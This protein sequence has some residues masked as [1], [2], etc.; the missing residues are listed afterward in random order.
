M[1]WVGANTKFWRL[2]I[3]LSL[4]L[5]SPCQ[6]VNQEL[7]WLLPQQEIVQIFHNGDALGQNKGSKGARTLVNITSVEGRSTSRA[8]K[9]RGPTAKQKN[10]SHAGKSRHAR[11]PQWCLQRPESLP[12]EG[13]L[14]QTWSIT[15]YL[16]L[17]KMYLQYI[18]KIQDWVN[19][20]FW[21][22]NCEEV[23]IKS[24]KPVCHRNWDNNYSTWSR[25]PAKAAWRAD[26]L[27]S[28]M[29]KH[30]GKGLKADL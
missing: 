26:N 20:P 1:W 15:F 12:D 16:G 19:A 23:G 21:F 10:N 11:M 4:G 28:D 22:G 7:C 2:K 27:C 5:N 17:K 24:L 13:N 6:C 29:G 30:E 3:Q 14:W 18:L 9:C 8:T 25:K